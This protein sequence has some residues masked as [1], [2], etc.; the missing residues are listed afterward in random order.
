MAGRGCVLVGRLES[1]ASGFSARQA[2][3]GPEAEVLLP[4]PASAG[5]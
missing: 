2:P 1:E 4:G 3:R 5:E